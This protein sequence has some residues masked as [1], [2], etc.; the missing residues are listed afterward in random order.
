IGS[1][2]CNKKE[3]EELR[4]ENEELTEQVKK[5]DSRI[6]ELKNQLSRVEKNLESMIENKSPGDLSGLEKVGK[7]RQRL[8]KVNELVQE[9]KE[10][11]ED[12]EKDLS[13]ARYQANKYKK[14]ADN[15][16]KELK[17]HKDSLQVITEDLEAKAEKIKEMTSKMDEQE[18]EIDELSK[19]NQTYLDSLKKQTN[20]LN[21][22]YIAVNS[23]KNLENKNIIK[24]EGGFLGFLG[25]TWILD[26][27]FS[28][29]DFKPF[30]KVEENKITIDAKKRK[31]E[32][33]T[34][35]PE[36][37]YTMKEEEDDKTVLEITD[38]EKFWRASKHLV[39]AY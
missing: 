8:E 28:E 38:P 34:S 19:E 37:A 13:G 29:S 31:A 25:Q 39:I 33:I 18:S 21:T 5:K 9:T 11:R 32:V 26:P 23:G 27:T 14:E 16:D 36:N 4:Q 35:H 6:K 2:G 3:L 7:L 20:K 1:V 10:K 30:N 17:E 12:F 24:K 22:A 15:L